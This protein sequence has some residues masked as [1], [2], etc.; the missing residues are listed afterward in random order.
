MPARTHLRREGSCDPHIN[1]ERTHLNQ[2]C[3]GEPAAAD[4]IRT[5]QPT[6]SRNTRS[7]ANFVDSVIC[8]LPDEF[9]PDSPEQIKAWQEATLKW[10]RQDCPGTL[11]CAVLLMDESRPHIHAQIISEDDRKH[12]SWKDHLHGRDILRALHKMHD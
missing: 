3:A 8:T 10:L 6:S 11:K 2:T 5:H 4:G 12:L 9:D 1:T 7:D